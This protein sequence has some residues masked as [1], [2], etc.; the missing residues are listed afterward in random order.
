M[1]DGEDDLYQG[2]DLQDEF[3]ELLLDENQRPATAAGQKRQ[4]YTA[5]NR[6][7]TRGMLSTAGSPWRQ[8]TA[9]P[10]TAAA[11]PG[12]SWQAASSASRPVT[13]TTGAGYSSGSGKPARGS[14]TPPSRGPLGKALS[15]GDAMPSA[16]VYKQTE[17][18]VHELLEASCLLHSQSDPNSALQKAKEAVKKERQLEKLHQQLHKGTPRNDGLAFST[19]LQLALMHEAAGLPT[20]ALRIYQALLKNKASL[21]AGL[22]QLNIGNLM[23]RKGDLAGCMRAY[24]IALDNIAPAQRSSRIC[25]LR[26]L[27]MAQAGAGQYTD[28]AKT[29]QHAL[30][31]GTDAAATH[32]LLV[33][34]YALG[35]VTAMQ[36]NFRKLV[37]IRGQQSPPDED[38]PGDGDGGGP[39]SAPESPHQDEHQLL[40]FVKGA[41]K[42]LAPSLDEEGMAGYD[43]CIKQC[44]EAGWDAAVHELT[45]VK[46]AGLLRHHN[47]QGAMDL[48]QGLR[49]PASKVEAKAAANLAF[50]HG[51]AGAPQ[52]AEGCADAALE[53][54]HYSAVA[55]VNKGCA[56]ALQGKLG[57]ARA[58]FDEAS[59]IDP[60]CGPANY[61]R[62]LL[63]KRQSRWEDAMDTF[64]QL[65]AREPENV[66]YLWQ[67]ADTLDHMEE[68]SGAVEWLERLLSRVP[69]DPG[70]LTRLGSLHARLGDEPEA[71][72]Y[73]SEAHRVYP[74]DLGALSWMGA[75][76]VRAQMFDDAMP[77][78]KLAARIQPHEVKWALMVA[79]CLRRL[80]LQAE[81]LQNYKQIHAAHPTN[82]ECLRYLVHL[83][84]DLG[85]EDDAHEYALRLQR[86]ERRNPDA[87]NVQA[88]PGSAMPPAPMLPTLPT[89]SIPEPLPGYIHVP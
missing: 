51:L 59:A 82:I 17:K 66:L 34:C 62:G 30:E 74:G 11:R 25:T 21:Q 61:N 81:A 3:Q 36:D 18:R 54:D 58:I 23:L 39:A 67:I 33:C 89:S 85:W 56:M 84:S 28:A 49:D 78:F 77:H 53:E 63:D 57:P 19:C 71:W 15:Q 73:Y 32:N 83:C 8:P 9:V 42:L 40:G 24:R 38:G 7:G 47:H 55:L 60:A 41:A 46:S 4:T 20:E 65:H 12:S 88:R 44:Q 48:L 5:E 72:R 26:N 2:Y 79:S 45:L 80:G 35:D 76:Y 37:Q 16:A 29:L 68:L 22:V 75:Y 1:A 86:A 64:Q 10:G 43:W 6:P 14:R 52:A 27:A 70:V 87:A 31:L 69:N 50:L 13:S